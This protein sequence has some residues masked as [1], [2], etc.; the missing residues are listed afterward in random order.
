MKV[1]L[2][3]FVEHLGDP[4]DEVNVAQGYARNFLI[5]NKLAFAA[6][7]SAVKDYQNNLRQR[8]R[9]LAK[10]VTEAEALKASLEAAGDL[11]FTRRAGPDGKLFGSVTAADVEEALQAKGFTLDKRKIQLGQPIKSLGEANVT[12]KLHAKVSA[13]LKVVV[14]AEVEEAAPE[15]APGEEAAP[16]GE[17]PAA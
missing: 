12:V 8:A 14:Q 15:A 6:T 7:P 1:I 2:T 16:S 11:V 9:K 4:G 5:P 10:M 3:D 17:T 13:S